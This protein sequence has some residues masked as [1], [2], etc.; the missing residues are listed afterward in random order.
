[1]EKV[2][3]VKRVASKLH[4]TEA[5][6]DV[7]MVQA[8]EMMAELVQARKDLRVSATV[9]SAATAKVMAALAALSEARTAMIE[10]H[11]ELDQTRLRLGVRTKMMGWDP[12]EGS[13]EV[14]DERLSE[15]S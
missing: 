3:V 2:F 7:A 14:A 1:M 4:G 13:A 15:A 10:A 8:A 6:I 5:A 11:S 9:G 12:K